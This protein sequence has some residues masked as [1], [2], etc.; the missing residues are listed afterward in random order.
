MFV[1]F[2]EFRLDLNQRRLFAGDSEVLLT[3][4]CCELLLFLVQNP[5]R[6]LTR[7]ELVEHV[8]PETYVDDHSLSVQIAELR[9][10]LGDNP[11]QP[12]FIETRPRR[13]Y[14][15][16]ARSQALSTALP[17]A[18]S[19]ATASGDSSSSP[20]LSS[21]SGAA[22]RS[23]P[24][25]AIPHSS[26][27]LP[28][29]PRNA[30][31]AS[32]AFFPDHSTPPLPETF[33]AASG[34]YNIAYQVVGEG[35]VDLVFVMGWVS[36]LEYFWREPR[37]ARFLRQ[38][39]R[40]ARLIL[41]DKRG[42][43]LS[44]RVPSHQL[45]TLEQRMDDVRA[46]LDRVGSKEAVL[47]GVSE[48]GPMA[49][50]FAATYPHKTRG[51]IMFGSY[52]RRLRDADY[53]WG[54]TRDQRDVYC[55]QLREQW[56]GPVGIDERAP[57]L[58]ADPAFR[59]WWAEYLR[60][61]VSPGGAEALTRM[62]AEIDV[63]PVL[64]SVRVPTLILHRKQDQCLLH[65]EGEYLASL[66]PSARFVTLPGADHLPF[67]GNQEDVL[68]PIADFLANIDQPA[69]PETVLATVLALSP[70]HSSPNF[71]AKL[72]QQV[73]WFRGR[74]CETA[75]L[76]YCAVFDGPARAIRCGYALVKWLEGEGLSAKAALHTG[77]CHVAG[78]RTMGG[79][80][81]EVAGA[82]L[83][84]ANSEGVFASR[85]VKDLV[86]G[87]GIRFR[88]EGELRL[89]SEEVWPLFSVQES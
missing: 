73:Q 18:A 58:A 80:A 85:V 64:P 42:T 24:P 48:G 60:M 15:F 68:A 44:D 23:A 88:P 70:K 71:V 30:A 10:L 67:V 34:D 5:G 45:P 47:F 21:Q 26:A 40:N 11:R 75:H 29:T 55:R 17:A 84:Q 32:P 4:K 63:R 61:G 49:A 53:P 8:W 54:P 69:Q 83:E 50:L 74:L 39:S 82:I 35:P 36:H 72:Q 31:P 6:L 2:E 7:E 3:P 76:P 46:V 12:R 14:R 66:I 38:L 43:G 65:E 41:F 79:Y 81:I 62:N 51:L 37:F 33:Y 77:G 78:D 56:G 19:V 52:A 57:T 22:A 89:P 87:S 28:E 27:V 25:P 86:A 1:Q 20:S 13:G 9:K 59:A 16:L